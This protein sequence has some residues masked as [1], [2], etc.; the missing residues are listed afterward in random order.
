ML[1]LPRGVSPISG[2]GGTALP[3]PPNPKKVMSVMGSM[4]W[5]ASS[6][7]SP[8]LPSDCFTQIYTP[9]AV[10]VPAPRGGCLYATPQG[11]QLRTLRSASAGRLPVSSLRPLPAL[12]IA[13]VGRGGLGAAGGGNTGVG[14]PRLYSTP[15]PSPV[16]QRLLGGAAL[17]AGGG[18]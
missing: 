12:G 2:R 17:W 5:G 7:G 6:L 9:A 8:P 4:E 14:D 1:R 10:S 3:L 15:H 18:R 13:S 11:P 16:L